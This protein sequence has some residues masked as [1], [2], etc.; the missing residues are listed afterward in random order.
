M[1]CFKLND[2]RTGFRPCFCPVPMDQV[3]MTSVICEV[4]RTVIPDGREEVDNNPSHVAMCER[5]ESLLDAMAETDSFLDRAQQ[6]PVRVA[7]ADLAADLQR[8]I[9]YLEE[10]II[11][12]RRSVPQ[13]P[14]VVPP[15]TP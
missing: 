13:P 5:M 15:R 1:S 11:G 4:S 12:Y 2:C 3:F 10:A 14:P 7:L 8:D 9:T 6:L